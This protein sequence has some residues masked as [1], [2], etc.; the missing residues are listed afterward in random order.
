MRDP[1]LRIFELCINSM[2]CPKSHRMV[3]LVCLR[4]LRFNLLL[5]RLNSQLLICKMHS[6]SLADRRHS[7]KFSIQTFTSRAKR[8][9]SKLYMPMDFFPPNN[10][11]TLSLSKKNLHRTAAT[12][13]NY[14]IYI[15]RQLIKERNSITFRQF[16]NSFFI[17]LL[18]YVLKEKNESSWNHI[19]FL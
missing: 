7:Q 19:I 11:S 14:P 15:S 13:T 16:V 12:K 9:A 18:K 1:G 2:I 4:R 8:H 17:D 3:L 5:M 10:T 6:L